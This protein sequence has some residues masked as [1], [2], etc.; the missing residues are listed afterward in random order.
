MKMQYYQQSLGYDQDQNSEN[1]AEADEEEDDYVGADNQYAPLVEEEEFGDFVDSSSMAES[2]FQNDRNDFIADID[3]NQIDVFL[4]I[5]STTDL[6]KNFL[7]SG[8]LREG[9]RYQAST[10]TLTSTAAKSQSEQTITTSKSNDADDSD[11]TDTASAK[12]EDAYKS[13]VT[14]EKQLND[15]K[16]A[17]QGYVSIPPLSKDKVQTIKNIMANIKIKPP[18]TSSMLVADAIERSQVRLG[19]EI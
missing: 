1:D 19:D 18:T 5:E 9:K 3:T 12:G 6:E 15:S 7:F 2:Q 8:I 4:N 14:S 17:D 16:K 11:Q 10:S 13:E